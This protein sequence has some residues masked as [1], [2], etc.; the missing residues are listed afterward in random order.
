VRLA[1]TMRCQPTPPE[2]VLWRALRA[3]SLAGL[4]FRRQQP[5]GSYIVDFYCAAA[6]LVVEVDGAT[7]A[8]SRTDPARDAWLATRGIR[9]MRVWNNDVMSNLDGVLRVIGDTAT[10]PPGPLP[11]G[12]GERVGPGERP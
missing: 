9:V 11:Q 4:K 7:H 12:E 3:G 8:D 5:I 2:R 6:K 1:K 10:P